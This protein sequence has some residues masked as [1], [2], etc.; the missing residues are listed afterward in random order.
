M[1]YYSFHL[2]DYA[3]HTIHLSDDEDLAYRRL[4]DLYYQTE[5]PIT[6]DV[7]RAARLIR[8]P[9]QV[10]IVESVLNEFFQKTEDGYANKRCD[11]EIAKYQAKAV[12]AIAANNR[13][14]EAHNLK[15]DL[16]S[17]LK[18]APNQEPITNNQEPSKPKTSSS[19]AAPSDVVPAGFAEFWSAYPRKV[20]KGAAMKLWS[21]LKVNGHLP[22]VLAAIEAQKR[23]EQ[24]KRDCGQ[25]IPYPATWLGQGRWDD[26]VDTVARAASVGINPRN[27]L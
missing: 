12:R 27:V 16:K 13:R 9:T 22:K 23:S 2:G 3:V 25:F 1:N 11:I 24:W 15:S 8:K 21:R 5:K 7:E 14:W 6:L 19:S 17:D 18:S 20:G 10:A 4:I 26:D